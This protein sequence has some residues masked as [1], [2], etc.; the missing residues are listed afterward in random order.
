MMSQTPITLRWTGLAVALACTTIAC[1]CES[2]G[3][4]TETGAPNKN[5]TGSIRVSQNEA[6]PDWHACSRA[7]IRARVACRMRPCSD[8]AVDQTVCYEAVYAARAKRLPA[9]PV[10][11]LG[12]NF[13]Y[14]QANAVHLQDGSVSYRQEGEVGWVSPKAFA[15]AICTK[16]L[17]DLPRPAC[18]EELVFGAEDLDGSFGAGP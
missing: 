9:V 10:R 1:R 17:G 11:S 15:T 5:A 3:V 2:R 18:I 14:E 8:R 12:P 16:E 6:P 4:A 13:A 7:A